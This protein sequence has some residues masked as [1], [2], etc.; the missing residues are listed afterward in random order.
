MS[1]IEPSVNAPSLPLRRRPGRAGYTESELEGLVPALVGI[2]EQHTLARG[3]AKLRDVA[4]ALR[5]GEPVAEKLAQRAVE[6]GMLEKSAETSSRYRAVGTQMS[7]LQVPPAWSCRQETPEEEAQRYSSFIEAAE[8]WTRAYGPWSRQELA[9]RLEYRQH[10]TDCLLARAL[11]EGKVQKEGHRYVAVGTPIPADDTIPTGYTAHEWTQLRKDVDLWGRS[12]PGL[13]GAIAVVGHLKRTGRAVPLA[14][15]ERLLREL[16]NEGKILCPKNT[17]LGY[18]WLSQDREVVSLAT[19]HACALRHVDEA[20]SGECQDRCRM[21]RH[22]TRAGVATS[23]RS[24]FK[25]TA[26]IGSQLRTVP[27]HRSG[28]RRRARR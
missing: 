4:R 16:T 1:F 23:S 27:L 8:S 18:L 11:N 7:V 9:E 12:Q 28:V 20:A 21:T 24:G 3:S 10:R 5:L 6:R 22:A 2:V 13:V 26:L 25:R 17:K 19:L 14:F 15:A